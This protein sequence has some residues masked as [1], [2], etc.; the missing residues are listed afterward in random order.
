[1]RVEAGV[2]WQLLGETGLVKARR[3]LEEVAREIPFFAAAA[4]GVGLLGVEL[5][6]VAS[7]EPVAVEA[8]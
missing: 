2:Y 4:D 5:K 3:V 1:V 6:S 8:K 7:V